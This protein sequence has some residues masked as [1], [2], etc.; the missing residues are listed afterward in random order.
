MHKKTTH[1]IS[2]WS[3]PRN[4]STAL[5]YSFA[6]H[7]EIQVIDEPF[8]G[9]YLHET[10]IDHPGRAETLASMDLDF[11]KVARQVTTEAY[12]K[13]VLFLKNM[14]HHLVDQNWDFLPQLTNVLLLRHPTLVINSYLKQVPHPTLLDV[15]YELLWKLYIYLRELGQE[16]L[17]ID[18]VELLKNPRTVITAMCEACDIPFN[19]AMLSW[20][21]GARPEDGAWAPYWYD[22]V[23]ASTGFAPHV[24]RNVDLPSHVIELHDQCMEFYTPLFNKSLKAKD[25]GSTS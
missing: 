24:E 7:P 4:I 19:E 15:G 8:Y 17:I 21:A 6:Q 3:G 11:A 13:P 2:V 25:Y 22:N 18:S 10:G 12:D 5:M 20:P 1:R 14:A 9:A 23:H 16:P